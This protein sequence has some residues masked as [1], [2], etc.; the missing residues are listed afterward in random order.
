MAKKKHFH[1]YAAAFVVLLS[2]CIH[3]SNFDTVATLAG[4]K[5]EEKI[6]EVGDIVSITERTETFAK[7]YND[8]ILT[9]KEKGV[10]EISESAKQTIKA[11]SFCD[12]S[13]F[14]FSWVDLFNI[15]SFYKEVYINSATGAKSHQGSSF[16]NHLTK[17][18]SWDELEKEIY[19]N[20]INFTNNKSDI[21]P[22]SLS[23]VKIILKQI[24]EFSNDIKNKYPEFDLEHL[25][26]QL[27]TLSLMYGSNHKDGTLASTST[28]SI[29]WFLND[30]GD[31][32]ILQTSLG[33]NNHEFKHFLCQRCIDEDRLTNY[34][35]VPSGVVYGSNGSLSFSFI[36]EATAEEYSALRN[37]NFPVTY[38]D[39]IGILNNLRMVLS[40]QDDYEEDGFLKY[41]LLRNPLSM[42]QQFPVIDDQTYFFV[43]NL[44]MLAAFNACLDDNSFF[45]KEVEKK[46]GYQNCL[47]GSSLKK[48]V[49]SSCM[50]YA[51]V[52]LSRLFFT[53]LII[54]NEEKEE[55]TLEYNFYLM[56]LFEKRMKMAF[57]I[58]SSKQGISISPANF[59]GLNYER[60]LV[61]LRYL[62]KK[63]QMD[64]QTLKELYQEYSLSDN[65]NYPNFV[66]DSR[67]NF[68]K[69]LETQEYDVEELKNMSNS[70]FEYYIR[71]SRQ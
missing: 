32:P 50:N 34:Y 31:K 28:Y 44:K 18:I 57:D 21:C 7:D 45:I 60:V 52:E 5:M 59:E 64:F 19:K 30:S 1:V 55:M 39:K 41:A 46:V 66:D 51:Q 65:V 12:T 16:Y 54:M 63:Y 24:E 68:Y 17:T 47:D 27:S 43:D 11:I 4:Q 33:L 49:Y 26:C 20:S 3:V 9:M 2:G 23:D 69:M 38:H 29:E 71:Y 36:E 53:D 58:I 70:S 67:I 42:V 48:E 25:A 14:D 8:M 10:G 61:M 56:R 35:V 62:E 6:E 13:K 22:L 15:E 40:M 37:N